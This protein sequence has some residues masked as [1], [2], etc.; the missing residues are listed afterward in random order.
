M[1]LKSKLVDKK[2]GKEPC[3]LYTS[4]HSK[5]PAKPGR[6]F[7]DW[8]WARREDDSSGSNRRINRRRVS[9]FRRHDLQTLREVF[10]WLEIGPVV[11]GEH[12]G[13]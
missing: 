5:Y 4:L 7:P 8:A 11:L 13:F 9:G 6:D 10:N 1:D 3:L 12:Y 2:M